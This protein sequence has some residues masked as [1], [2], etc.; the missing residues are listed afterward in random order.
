MK[1]EDE[2]KYMIFHNNAN[3]THRIYHSYEVLFEIAF[4][5]YPLCKAIVMATRTTAL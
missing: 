5:R 4:V 2:K 1:K 3:I